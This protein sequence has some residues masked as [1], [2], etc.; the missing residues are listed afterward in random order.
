[1]RSLSTRGGTLRTCAP[2]EADHGRGTMTPTWQRQNC[3][4][5]RS[6]IAGAALPGASPEAETLD[7]GEPGDDLTEL[8]RLIAQPDP[9]WWD[10]DLAWDYLYPQLPF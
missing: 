3:S 7:D 2:V 6:L 5:D 4:V 1:V 10:Y 8:E 9:T